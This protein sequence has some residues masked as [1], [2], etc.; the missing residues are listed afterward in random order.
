MRHYRKYGNLA[1]TCLPFIDLERT[2]DSMNR[3][4]IWKML[5]G[6]KY[7]KMDGHTHIWTVP[8]LLSSSTSLFPVGSKGRLKVELEARLSFSLFCSV[9]RSGT[10]WFRRSFRQQMEAASGSSA[11]KTPSGWSGSH[12]PA[13]QWE[14]PERKYEHFQCMV[15]QILHCMYHIPLHKSRLQQPV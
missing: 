14:K 8:S 12:K 10:S 9:G 5:Y 3:Q 1:N 15:T 6:H 13:W 4:K 2:H 11:I 7:P